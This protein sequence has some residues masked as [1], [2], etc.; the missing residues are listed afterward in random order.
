MSPR[1]RDPYSYPAPPHHH[2]VSS[3]RHITTLLGNP[4]S[5]LPAPP[6]SIPP[7]P[8]RRKASP[9]ALTNHQPIH[10]RPSHPCVRDFPSSLTALAPP[11]DTR[12]VPLYR[13]KAWL[14]YSR[15]PVGGHDQAGL[16]GPSCLEGRGHTPANAT[17]SL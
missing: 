17:N 15:S 14:R 13:A 16:A 2:T 11:P 5:P 8:H 10:S 4:P 3:R 1:C 12:R 9:I 6:N 7:P